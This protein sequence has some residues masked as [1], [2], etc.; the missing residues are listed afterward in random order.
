MFLDIKKDI[1]TQESTICCHTIA[2][3]FNYSWL[4]TNLRALTFTNDIY[5][6]TKNSYVK[7]TMVLI[8]FNI[9][10]RKPKL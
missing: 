9:L 2:R 7:N 10:Q 8:K 4:K 5:Y 6:C 3:K 1:Y